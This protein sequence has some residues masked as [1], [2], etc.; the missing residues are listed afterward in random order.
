MTTADIAS[1]G[2]LSVQDLDGAPVRVGTA[3]EKGPAVMVF[4]R[5]FG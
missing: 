2:N 4:L 3:W 5:H 1:L